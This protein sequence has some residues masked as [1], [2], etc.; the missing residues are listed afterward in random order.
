MEKPA[1]Y[2]PELGRLSDIPRAT[3]FTGPTP[4][5]PMPNL[6]AACGGRATLYVK[7]DDCTELAFGGNK[8][9]QLEYYLGEAVAQDADTVLITGARKLGM[10][11]HIQLEERVATNDPTYRDSGNVLLDRL[12]GATLHTYPHG[13]DEAGADRELERIAEELT[14]AGKRPYIILLAPGHAP[15]GALGYVVTAW[16]MLGQIEAEGLHLDEIFV[17]SGSGATHAGL[18]FGL[19]ALGSDIRVIGVCVRRDAASQRPRIAARCREIAELLGTR[20]A[21]VPRESPEAGREHGFTIWLLDNE[22]RSK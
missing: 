15:L 16:E 7:R 10:A 1:T 2:P 12:L 6:G 22:G 21:L 13:E 8:V 3:L 20:V 18:L 14:A 4:L 9:R 5:Q 17:A 11:C 19:R